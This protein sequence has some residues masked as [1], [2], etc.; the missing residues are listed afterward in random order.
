MSRLSYIWVARVKGAYLWVNIL[1]LGVL[2]PEHGSTQPGQLTSINKK[3]IS[4]TQP[5]M[6][7][8]MCKYK[9]GVD[10]ATAQTR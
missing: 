10:V 2:L 9:G 7:G 5:W 1:I 4:I 6:F 3:G 8:N